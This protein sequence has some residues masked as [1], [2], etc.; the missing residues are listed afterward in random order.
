M[1]TIERFAR[2]IDVAQQRNRGTSVIFGVMKK[3]GDDNA[4]T[5]VG[6]LAASAFGSIFPLLLLLFTVLG[7]VLNSHSG[8]RADVLHSTLRQFPIIGTDLGNNI[9]ALHRNSAVG[10]TVGI[11]GLAWGSLGLAQNGIFTMAQ[12]W[13]LPGVD[14]PNYLKRLYRSVIFLVVLGI[15]LIIST[16]LAAAVPTARGAIGWAIAGAVASAVVNFGEYLFAFRVLTPALVS[17]RQLVPGA[18]LAGF[19]WTVLQAAGG[20]V[21]G[22]YLK[23]DNA[24]Y[25][26][27]GIVL[28]LYAWVYLMTEVTVYAA[29]L[30][31][32]LARRLW[33]RSMVQPPL[34]DADRRS[35]AAQADQNRRRPEQHIEVSFDED[36][37]PKA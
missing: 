16:F 4:G 23:N 24:V 3:F 13:N 35:L 15:G 22:R 11:V 29:E 2:K 28:G 18:A 27:F 34:T 9:K 30:N 37:L 10:L 7:L 19:A 36:P 26:L 1:N 25:G 12:I 14:R 32:V 8:L 17:V 33:P 5:L 6:S 21:I 31:V 20:F